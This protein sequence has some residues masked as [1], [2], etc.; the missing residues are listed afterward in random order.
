MKTRKILLDV[1]EENEE[2]NLGLI[3]LVK[4]FPEHELYFQLNALNPFKFSRISDVI[5]HGQYYDSHYSRFQ[6]YLPDSKICLQCISN[7]PFQTLM[8][9]TPPELFSGEEEIKFLLDNFQDVDYLLKTSEPFDDF[10]LI[11]HPENIMF[12]I[13][14]FP[15]SPKEEL[16]QVIQYYD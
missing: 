11:L 16:Y 5:F 1:E 14:I 3:R 2:L 6:T 8:Q 15:L 12:P 10:S 13:Q 7:K 9:I 4:A